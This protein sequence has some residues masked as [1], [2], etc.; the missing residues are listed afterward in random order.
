MIFPNIFDKKYIN[1]GFL[2]KKDVKLILNMKKNIDSSNISYCHQIHSDI[3]LK[4]NKSWFLWDCDA[5]YTDKKNI[6]CIIQVADC[7]PIFFSYISEKIKIVWVIHSGWKWTV[8]NIVWKTFSFLKKK[9]ADTDFVNFNVFVWP[10]ICHNCYWFWKEA[11]D[12]FDKKYVKKIWDKFFVDVRWNVVDQLLLSWIEK[13][14]IEVS[15]LCSF[16]NKNLFYS[17]RRW[18]DKWR[19]IW[20]IELI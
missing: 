8:K 20:Y 14:H 11:V 1:S 18:K 16:E 9:Y 10:S 17:R 15:D 5:I 6:K 4:A 7:V 12:L 2:T 3:L 13:K 19:M